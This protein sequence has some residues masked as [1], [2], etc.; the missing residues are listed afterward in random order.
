MRWIS[1]VAGG[2]LL[3]VM[4]SSVLRTLVV[5]RGLYSTLVYR[6][7]WTLRRLLR[8]TAPRGDYGAID[9]AQTWLAPLVLIGMLATWLGGALAGFGMVL[10]ALSGLPWGSSF[11]EAAPACSPSASPA[12]PGCGCPRWTSSRRPPAPSSSP[13]RSPTCPRSTPPTTAV[14]WR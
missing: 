3:A 14:N 5:P 11:R 1:G 9:R 4:V 6:L 8:L 12:A 13:S 10:H 2:L 7:W